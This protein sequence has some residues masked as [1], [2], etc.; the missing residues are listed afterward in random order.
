MFRAGI[1][2]H[3]DLV[4]GH[5]TVEHVV[6]QF[7]LANLVEIFG[8]NGRDAAKDGNEQAPAHGHERDEFP[9]VEFG[10]QI[11][12][13]WLPFLTSAISRLRKYHPTVIRVKTISIVIPA[14]FPSLLTP[15]AFAYSFLTRFK[16]TK[17]VVGCSAAVAEPAGQATVAPEWGTPEIGPPECAE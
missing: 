3:A 2:Y 6:F 16:T 10:Q 5:A 11:P 8:D 14:D 15:R 13:R 7:Q 4:R 1:E 17:M 9:R 12:H